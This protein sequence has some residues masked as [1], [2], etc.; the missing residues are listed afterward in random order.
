MILKNEVGV[1]FMMVGQ[2]RDSWGD[3]GGWVAHE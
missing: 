2:G 3:W 1:C